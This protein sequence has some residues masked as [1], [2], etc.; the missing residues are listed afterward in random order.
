M[1][2]GSANRKVVAQSSSDVPNHPQPTNFMHAEHPVGGPDEMIK[3]KGMQQKVTR[4]EDAIT[5][6]RVPY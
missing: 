6:F 5:S 2:D 3:A 1:P 4:G